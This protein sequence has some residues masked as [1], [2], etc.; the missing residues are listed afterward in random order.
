MQGIYVMSKQKDL[1][2][3]IATLYLYENV[4]IYGKEGPWAFAAPANSVEDAY[5]LFIEKLK[6]KSLW[7]KD[8]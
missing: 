2:F 7:K 5:N 1:N 8:I 6:G 4:I 3:E